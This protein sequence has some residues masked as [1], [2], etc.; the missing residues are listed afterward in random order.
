[1]GERW[2]TGARGGHVGWPP[3]SLRR[4]LRAAAKAAMRQ[5]GLACYRVVAPGTG[6]PARDG[7]PYL[8]ALPWRAALGG[9]SRPNWPGRHIAARPHPP[10]CGMLSAATLRPGCQT[11]PCIPVTAIAMRGACPRSARRGR[12]S[13]ACESASL[14]ESSTRQPLAWRGLCSAARP[15]PGRS[16]RPRI[17]SEREGRFSIWQP[18]AFL[19]VLSE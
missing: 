6:T 15:I 9:S 3:P 4:L 11:L 19:V 10:L 8:R 18:R 17:V 2:S 7:R 14:L 1:M 12:S 13:R 5:R 16:F